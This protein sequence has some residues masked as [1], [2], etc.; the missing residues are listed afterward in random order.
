MYT[1]CIQYTCRQNNPVLL[2]VPDQAKISK[3]CATVQPTFT[4]TDLMTAGCQVFFIFHPA[5]LIHPG[6]LT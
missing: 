4:F 2:V 1:Y 3:S 6:N 5:K